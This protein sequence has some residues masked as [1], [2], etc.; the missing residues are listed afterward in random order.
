MTLQ[1]FDKLSRHEKVA[2]RQGYL[3]YNDYQN[4]L[5]IRKGFKN[6]IDYENS[7]AIK[8]G[9]KN[10]SD[11]NLKRSHL[12]GKNNSMSKNKS[13]SLYLGVHIAERILSKVFENVQRMPNKNQGYDF[14]CK[15]GFKIDVKSSCLCKKG[16]SWNF[17][18][19]N[20]KIADYFLLLAFDTRES[21]NPKYI[22]LI[23]GIECI[24]TRKRG[25]SLN[26]KKMLTITNSSD[27]LSFINYKKYEQTDKL[28]KLIDCCN[29]IK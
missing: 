20:N 3:N 7:I 14:I 23:K 27:S 6:R 18:I 4:A 22:W 24:N 8:N 21:L 26:N 29:S 17:N 13:C 2:R 9:Y 12:L 28:K 19:N 5:A 1:E 15:N 10:F 16:N 11:Y 25:I